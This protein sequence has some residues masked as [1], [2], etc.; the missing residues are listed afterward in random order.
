M[1]W[2]KINKRRLIGDREYQVELTN[3]KSVIREGLTEVTMEQRPVGREEV[4]QAG[5]W[6]KT[7]QEEGAV[8]CRALRQ[9][10]TWGGQGP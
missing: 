2:R 7:F 9:A 3:L 5:T 10:Y 8:R 4:S 1:L 6:R